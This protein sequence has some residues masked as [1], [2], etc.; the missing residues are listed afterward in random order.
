MAWKYEPMG[1]PDA[2]I[3][4]KEA[5]YIIVNA[6]SKRDRVLFQLLSRSGRRVTEV[7]TLKPI[8]IMWD[9]QE[10]KWNILKK[11]K[12][13]KIAL[14]IDVATLWLLKD[15]LTSLADTKNKIEDYDYVF[16]SYGKTGHLTDRRVR[17]LLLS[18]AKKGGFE[19]VGGE[20]VHPHHF[21]HGFAIHFVKNMKRPD[22]IFQLQKILQHADIRETMWYVDHFGKSEVKELIDVMWSD[23][24]SAVQPED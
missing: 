2:Y 10:I 24:T 22:Q 21:R 7:L 6:R 8:D 17:Y 18:Y 13:L 15:Y 16:K 20:K 23:Q 3:S 14:P 9:N 1:S 5:D 11:R 4:K 19:E 12:P